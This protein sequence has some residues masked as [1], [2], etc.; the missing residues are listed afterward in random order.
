M[1]PPETSQSGSYVPPVFPRPTL[2][3]F[4]QHTEGPFTSPEAESNPVWPGAG[5]YMATPTN[6]LSFADLIG[7]GPK[8]DQSESGTTDA[9]S[10]T[11][12]PRVS[13]LMR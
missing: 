1:A 5:E 9:S 12:S 3:L 6:H 11:N 13:S 2:D 4:D 8:M 10:A 7:G